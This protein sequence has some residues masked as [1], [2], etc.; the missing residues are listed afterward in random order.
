MH[1][2]SHQAYS[3]VRAMRDAAR[4]TKSDRTSSSNPGLSPEALRE[5]PVSQAWAL[6]GVRVPSYRQRTVWARVHCDVASGWFGDQARPRHWTPSCQDLSAYG[7]VGS[8]S[9]N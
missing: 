6:A 3:R 7:L 9:R 1:S 5:L 4:G 2:R 8:Y